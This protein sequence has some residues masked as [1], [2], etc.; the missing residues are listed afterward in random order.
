MSNPFDQF[1]AVTLQ[2]DSNPFDQ[3]DAGKKKDSR[4][5]V[6]EIANQFKAGIL[7]DLPKMAG[8]ALKYTSDPGNKVYEAGQGITDWADEQGKRPDLAP[9][10]DQHNIVTNAL[11]S[12]ARMIPQSVA[13]AAAVGAGILALPASIPATVGLGAASVLGA[14]PAAMSQGQETLEKAREKGIPEDQ[15]LAAARSNALIEG[16]GEALGTYAG[17][18]LLGIAGKTVGKMFG[19][20][21]GDALADQTS[22]AIT[23]PFLKQLGETALVETGTEIGQ[24][25]GEAAVEN[26]YG[27]DS[28]TPYQA[29]KEAIAPT[30]GMTALLAPFGL[31]GFAHAAKQRGE[32]TNALASAETT[33]EDRQKIAGEF[34]AEIGK[35]DKNAAANF[36]ANAQ[37]AIDGKQALSIGESM[38]LPPVAAEETP[39]PLALPAPTYTGTPGDQVMAA[40]VERQNQVDA[41]QK[42]SDALYAERA[43][44]EQANAPETGYVAP[45]IPVVGPLSAAANLAVQSGAHAATVAQQQAAIENSQAEASSTQPGKAD[46]PTT[47][48]REA[49]PQAGILA[50]IAAQAPSV[51]P[52][53]PNT[54]PQGQGGMPATAQQAG[55]AATSPAGGEFDVSKRTNQQLEYLS[56][57]GQPGWK[58]AAVAEL[59]K[60]SVQVSATQQA[61]SDTLSAEKPANSATV[62]AQKAEDSAKTPAAPVEV[63]V[64]V[65]Q[66]QKAKGEKLIFINGEQVGVVSRARS[67]GTSDWGFR[68]SLSGELHFTEEK[69]VAAETEAAKKHYSNRIK[70]AAMEAEMPPAAETK[71][72]P[73]NKKPTE[74]PTFWTSSTPA[75][76]KWIMDASGM[77]QYT[78]MT[79]WNRI[80]PEHQALLIEQWGDKPANQNTVKNEAPAAATVSEE[81]TVP[82]QEPIKNQSGESTEMVNPVSQPKTDAAPEAKQDKAPAITPQHVEN[83]ESEPATAAVVEQSL[84]KGAANS[85][86]DLRQ[87]RDLLLKK[88]DS[89]IAAAPT[90]EEKDAWNRVE[91]R[92]DLAN[93][94]HVAD[95]I[96][97]R[98]FDVP[99]DG[100]FKVLNLKEALQR[101]RDRVEANPGFKKAVNATGLQ[102]VAPWQRTTSGGTEAT[103]KELLDQGEYSAA[104]EYAKQ[105]GKPLIFGQYQDGSA[106]TVYT[107]AKP[108][109]REGYDDFNMVSVRAVGAADKVAWAVV[110]LNS[111]LTVSSKHPTRLKAIAETNKA[112]EKTTPEQMATAVRS[113]KANMPG[114]V[115][116]QEELEQRWLV[117]VEQR[118]ADA[119]AKAEQEHRKGLRSHRGMIAD[120]TG[121]PSE[122]VGKK[123]AQAES[124]KVDYKGF[125]RVDAGYGKFELHDGNMVVKVESTSSG[126]YQ[127]SFRGAKSSP[128]LVGEQGAID[129]AASYRNAARQ[130][131]TDDQRYERIRATPVMQRDDKDVKWANEYKG[132][133]QRSE[134][135]AE[136]KKAEEQKAAIK[137]DSINGFLD[138]KAPM[139]A[140]AIR[141]ALNKQWRF[142][143]VVMTARDRIESLWRDG[144]LA[145]STY[146]EN[147]IKPMSRR[148]F[149]RASQREQDAHEKKMRE[150][151]TKTV[152]VVSE[153][154]LGKIA[155]DYAQHLLAKNAEVKPSEVAIELGGGQIAAK[156]EKPL[157]ETTKE[158]LIEQIKQ[159]NLQGWK[160]GNLR[161]FTEKHGESIKAAMDAGKTVPDDVLADYPGLIRDDLTDDQR[162]KMAD[163]LAG[164][165]G[166]ERTRAIRAWS[167]KENREYAKQV[168]NN[169]QRNFRNIDALNPLTAPVEDGNWFN[170]GG[171]DWQARNG[172]TGRGWALIDADKKTHP[173]INNIDAN[174][175][176]IREIVQANESAKSGDSNPTVAAEKPAESKA[177][178]AT[179]DAGEELTYNKRN[180]RAGGVK[181]DD[182]KDKNTALRVKEVVKAKVY[183]KP[184]YQ[185]LVDGGMKDVV[186]HIV[187]QAYDAIAPKPK[188]SRGAEA[189]DEALQ[190]YITAVNRVMDGVMKWASDDAAVAKWAAKQSKLAG[191]SINISELAA[192]ST[193][194]DTVYPNG[195]KANR[196][197]LIMLGGNKLLGALQPGYDEV[198]RAM[199]DIKLGWPASVESWQKQGM[200]VVHVDTLTVDL[201]ASP[202]RPN[203]AAYVSGMLSVGK[204]RI[205]TFVING[206]DNKEDQVVQ[207]V[208]ADRK[209]ELE[210]KYVLLDKSG[211]PLGVF[212]GEDSAA[213]AAREKAKK[214]TGEKISEKGV[215]VEMAERVGIDHR[216]PGDDVT[217][218]RLK[219]TFGF[220][221]VNFGNWMQGDT[222]AKVAERQLHLNHL[223]DAFMD[224]AQL[225]NL[226]PKAMS[227]NGMLGIAV[228]AQGSGKALAHFVPGVNE[229]NVTRTKGAGALAHE[230][231]HALDHYFA[232][233]GG[234]D[235]KAEPYLSAHVGTLDGRVVDGKYVR[236]PV[237]LAEVR[238]E[239]AEQ[240][241]SIVEAMTKRKETKEE[242]ESRLKSEKTIAGR[243]VADEIKKIVD[244]IEKAK[245][246]WGTPELISKIRGLAERIAKLD[247]GDGRVAVLGGDA[248]AV[249]AEIGDA[250]LQAS[251][252]PLPNAYALGYHADRYKVIAELLESAEK[253]E[254]RT[255]T[256]DYQKAS[257]QADGKTRKYWATK[258]EMFARAF[259]AYVV[260][261]LAEK[262]EKN[263]YLS[264]IEAVAPQGD[265]RKAIGKAFDFLFA[266]LKTKET[267]RGTAIY[268]ITGKT[269][270]L[271]PADTA[272]YGMASDG[273]SAAEILKFIASA[274]R[275]PFYRQLAKL[276]LKTG[277]A[278]QVMAST[279]EG[280]RFNAGN[281]KKYAAAYN[282]STNTIAL[283]RPA[284]AERNFL[285]EAMHAATIRALGRK[286]L[287]SGQMK[288]LFEHVKKNGNLKGMYGM[289]DIDEF[290]AE[291]FSN[292]KFQDALKKIAAPKASGSTLSSA[293]D[294]FV[295]VVRGILGLKQNDDSA[296][297]QALEIGV[298]VMREDMKLRKDGPTIPFAEISGNEIDRILG[299][300]IQEKATNW[301][302]S[303]LQGKSFV[304]DETGWDISVGRKGINKAMMHAAKD[305]HARS[306]AAIP[307]LLKNAV[308]VASEE[309]RN[310]EERKSVPFVHH[311]YA[312][313]RI[314]GVDYVARLVVKEAKDGTRFYDYETSDEISPA[315]PDKFLPFTQR[316]GNSPSARLDMSM[317]E[318]LS[319]V[320]AEH[321]GTD[322][323]FI[324]YAAGPKQTDSAAFRKWFGKSKVVDE[325]GQPLVVYHGTSDDFTVFGNKYAGRTWEMFSD[326]SEYSNRFASSRGG[327]LVPVY[328]SLRNPLD[329]RSLPAIRGDVRNKLI[330][331]LEDAGVKFGNNF[332]MSDLPYERDLFQIV[333]MAGH[334]SGFADAVMAAGY[335]GIIM[336]DNHDGDYLDDG[337]IIATTYIALNPGQ[338]KSAIGNSGDFD[339][340]NPD[341]RYNVA[342]D[343]WSVS[344]PS[345]MD[346]LIYAMQD[347]QID[348]RRVVQSIM[349]TGKKVKDEVNAYLQEELFHGR[350]AKG[351][352]DFL[353]FELRPLLKQMQEAKVD[354][355]DFE[356]YLWNRHAE[357][358]NKQIAKINPDMPDGGSGIETAKARAYLAGLSAEQR[359]T[360]EAL[361]AKVETMNRESQRVLV[362]S[363]LEKQ[364]TIDAWNGAYQHYV[365][366]QREDVDSGHVGTGKGFSVRGSSSKRAMG[367]GKKVVDIIANLTMQ[368]ER[369]IVR[370][371]KN[372][373]SN[374][375]LGLAVQNPNPDFWKVDQA[376][377][378]RVV[379][380]KAIYTVLDSAGNKIEEFTRMD[381]AER[382][383]NKTPGASIDQAWGDRVTERVMPGFTSRDNVLLTRINGEDHYVIFNERD[384]R[385]M[386][387]ATA[388][389]NLDMDNLGRV[390]SVVGKA[391]R[392]L[393]SINTQYN[394]VFGVINL[395]R[396]AQGALINLSSTPLAGEQKRV[397]GYTKD[398]LVG[399]Y[400][401]IRAHRAGGKPSSNW[402]ALFE[403]FQKE[404]GQTG[405]RDQ[406]ANAEARAESIKSELEQFKDGKA[407]QLARGL[408]GWLSDYN[409]TMENAVRLAAYKA[410]KE[411]GMSKQ[412][413]A[414]LAKNITVNFNRKGQ[415]ATQVGSLYAF[416]NASVQG[417]ARIAGTLFDMKDGDIRTARLSSTGKKIVYGGIMLGSMQALLLA[418]AGFGDDEPPDFIKERN[419]I[420]PIG[421]GKYLTLA[422]PLGYHVFPGIGRLATEFVLSGGKDPLKKI[423]AF[424]S[425]FAEALN[426]IG[427]SG[428]SLQTITP[429]VIDPLAA[430]AENRDFTGKEIYQNDFNKL[431]PTPGFTRAKD[432]ATAWSKA[433]AEGLNFI[434][435]GTDY[436]P[437]LFTPT[438]DQIDYLIGQVTG[439]VGREVG[440]VS[441]VV[442]ATTTGEDLPIYKVPLVGRFVGDTQ[443]KSGESAKFYNSLREINMH[444]AEYKG[445]IGDGKRQEAAEYLAENPAVKLI[446]LGNQSERAVKKLK[447]AK[448]NLIENDAP[449]EK[450]A[451]ME[452]QIAK[453]MKLFNDRVTKALAQ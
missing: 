92:I 228:G 116:T 398:A 249:V 259:D 355:G 105:I 338:I 373:V 391:T 227:L 179:A 332:K 41:A 403:E 75:H 312:P 130:N 263:S 113:A 216:L 410:A 241:Q 221:G 299:R 400:K 377:K 207:E 258:L 362:E 134:A 431:N 379:Q 108:F 204:Q 37:Y 447:E 173:T 427:N 194:L 45:V 235:R 385:A 226:P 124:S 165:D 452:D 36:M 334:K 97:Y 421:D 250:Y 191:G 406:Y 122:D 414:S 349:R 11:A 219:E 69:A 178:S 58:E 39:A 368:R 443:G 15:A 18:K 110:D 67:P 402:A 12:G 189:S 265:E 83:G 149:N 9:Q 192:A 76:R 346:D 56:Q 277:I 383:A 247:Y 222:K 81:T 358:R 143:G 25:S 64:E 339:G 342:D 321:G 185:A 304:N 238:P 217:S 353:D 169:S 276:L 316:M 128:H 296:L 359:K 87:E 157:I 123:P 78:A 404:G 210:G 148:D 386:R 177:A 176:L 96:G 319:Y 48:N 343:G 423:A 93:N 366:L 196:D 322:P 445:L 433:I 82:K 188:L 153:S 70:V 112:L 387:M 261:S 166:A 103:V 84:M 335:D 129:W 172:Y 17:G 436:K 297:A 291:A 174:A 364:S 389:K 214:E 274:S 313:M 208:V 200:K 100:K 91:Q 180:R 2:G 306:V 33:P 139:Q 345:K 354:M 341:I 144:K 109:E 146:E 195:W 328:L 77:K 158:S 156:L 269:D 325:N 293:W 317:A 54:Q 315:V 44:F 99:G 31:A 374:A 351:V 246:K 298:G 347:K 42:K 60:R 290:V 388:M 107:E 136:A 32:R 272:I 121:K 66:N 303:N 127:A 329:M 289:S 117:N 439:G 111:G 418:A 236:S 243:L 371:E 260:D 446:M 8:Q 142:D 453:S 223:Y 237:A 396:D 310:A 369:N 350:A 412:Q 119:Q 23:K 162:D 268:N 211:R 324:R 305:I 170:I 3:F 154:E 248:P 327:R 245:T 266:E 62:P 152:Y 68:G 348:M 13:P 79:P 308:L 283:F 21:A 365:P 101:F 405:Y 284:A 114:I 301:M 393:A 85:P 20:T 233:M 314:G 309:N 415:M 168:D 282:E 234:L 28:K 187:K 163:D 428:F 395:I 357:E 7:V 55:P 184:D 434:T 429:S 61:K 264:G 242:H 257:D 363:G 311:L 417:T 381:D 80:K 19:R 407:K 104:N 43:A 118:E 131:E 392:Y 137:A 420:L 384:E 135:E 89:A 183:P 22:T 425:M 213:E 209:R 256:T 120:A 295:R 323:K 52:T 71:P 399:I 240:F 432:T 361:A 333:N 4:S 74:P 14:V 225:L 175:D 287:A 86:L 437:G 10:E 133:Q 231:G 422:M 63:N 199:R 438:P 330:P 252:A 140:G 244:G 72:K 212:D 360:F 90:A 239:V 161:L 138:G 394:P 281:D 372:R 95:T 294:W 46:T 275:S 29:G 16:G 88:V 40:E 51:A 380:E 47:G 267:E 73:E 430:L 147:K 24:N 232:T 340:T 141:N 251:G 38:F 205:D 132:R 376:P 98:I 285:H 224:L 94:M 273:K 35:V 106:I 102:K 151:G 370:A 441:Q 419:L 230:W 382:L 375:L 203:R 5:A 397:L 331:L 65:R 367:S 125:K 1:D 271:S 30:L 390:L 416:F 435:G 408:F 448:R 450:V 318:L 409:E 167:P 344:E 307:T 286:G 337:G 352:K 218:E 26:A 155:H 280:W 302:R 440:K 206:T 270:S 449:Q 202:A 59:K 34:A 115:G 356:E 411:K 50:G 164:I 150:A 160:D 424:G 181:W 186:A 253:W 326:S 426:P 262:E 6:G 401:D 336:P 57:H 193:L 378:E 278:P 451:A 182:I 279:T 215:S 126:K 288:A 27:I 320:K 413:A 145:V 190:T 229:I 201:Y 53:A 300:T 444:E 49:A 255:V 171:K 159:Q 442:S 220:R 292:P 197:E 254:P 198:G